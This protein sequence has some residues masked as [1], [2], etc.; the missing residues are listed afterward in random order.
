MSP[1]NKTKQRKK[2]RLMVVRVLVTLPMT[3]EYLLT[4]RF[5]SGKEV[6]GIEEKPSMSTKSLSVEP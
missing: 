3:M 5:S 4:W 1:Q 2:T 6:S